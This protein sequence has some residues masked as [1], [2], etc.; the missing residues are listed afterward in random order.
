MPSRKK[1]CWQFFLP[2]HKLQYLY[3][4]FGFSQQ[5]ASESNGLLTLK[6]LAPTFSSANFLSPN[7]V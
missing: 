1:H 2:N 5:Q 6:C 4:A 7:F 3:L